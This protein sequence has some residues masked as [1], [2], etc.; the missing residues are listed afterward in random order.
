MLSA[1]V[2]RRLEALGTI[3]Q[4]GKRMNGLFR[5]R[6]RYCRFLALLRD[7][8]AQESPRHD[9]RT[10]PL[11]VLPLCRLPALSLLPGTM[12]VQANGSVVF[13]SCSSPGLG[14]RCVLPILAV[15]RRC[16]CIRCCTRL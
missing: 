12:R 15:D 13:S 5:E 14:V 9:D 4:Q 6:A 3:S 16:C 11:R 8:P 2:I 10:T 7:L 1:T